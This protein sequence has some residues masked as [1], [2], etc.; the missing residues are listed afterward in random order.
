LFDA[1]TAVAERTVV[2][3]EQLPAGRV[4]QEYPECAAHVKTHEAEG[5]VGTR[6]LTEPRAVDHVEVMALEI[7][8]ILPDQRP[9]LRLGD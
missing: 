6:P 3:R 8:R 9:Q 1:H 2:A 7:T 5:V 4:V